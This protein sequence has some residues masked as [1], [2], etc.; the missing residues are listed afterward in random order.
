MN[1]RDF[2]RSC[3]ACS[4]ALAVPWAPIAG[5]PTPASAQLHGE[6]GLLG[7][8]HSP[9]FE[10]LTDDF[11][12]CTLC[13]RGCEFGPGERGHCRVRENR[14]GNLSSL[15]HGNPCAV[16]V[17]PIEKKPF[18][19][20][21][22]GSLAFSVATAGCNLDCKFCQ[23]WE[24]SQTE[25]DRTYNF[26]LPPGEA[27]ALAARHGC[28]STCSTYVEPTI[29]MEY[30]QDIGRAAKK[31]GLLNTMHSN[32]FVNP[33]P[34]E[35]LCGVL[36]AACIDLKGF[37]EEYYVSM[38]G[39]RL[40]PVLRSLELMREKGVWLELVTLIVPGRNDDPGDVAAMCGWVRDHLGPE[41][42]LHLTRFTPR[43]KL[44]A[45]P[46]TPVR[47]LETAYEIAREEGLNFVYIG[48]VPGHPA[49][50]TR[51][52]SCNDVIITR[53]GF[54]SEIAG[55]ADGKCSVCGTSIPGIWDREKVRDSS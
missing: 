6:R 48:N 35:D 1:R 23:N 32:G 22:P 42:P 43:Y 25:P 51:C 39:G 2:L 27:A 16:N 54:K 26:D 28:T 47:T 24:I 3:A 14:G 33:A 13:P 46:P 12:R 21:L 44:K 7:I 10:P 30:M 4:L 45:L 41:T 5:G 34:L 40:E 31:V 8:H 11:V 18:F 38:T 53:T 19:H 9:Y 37:T 29:F 20:V 55:L 52:P 15:V 17:D 50:N 36:D 49:E